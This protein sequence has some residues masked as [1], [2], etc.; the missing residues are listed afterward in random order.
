MKLCNPRTAHHACQFGVRKAGFVASPRDGSPP[1][2]SR[3]G[4]LLAPSHG[5]QLPAPSRGV[6]PSHGGE[7]ALPKF[8]C[9]RAAL[10]ALR[11]TVVQLHPSDTNL[12]VCFSKTSRGVRLAGLGYRGAPTRM[13]LQPRSPELTAPQARDVCAR[14]AGAGRVAWRHSAAPNQSRHFWRDMPQHEGTV[15]HSPLSPHTH[16]FYHQ[17]RDLE[18][19]LS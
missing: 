1:T 18:T 17:P 16:R 7:Q 11:Q 19:I 15:G 9:S 12:G 8:L 3:T 13:W 2:G 10:P 14:D 5:L 4:A 6:L